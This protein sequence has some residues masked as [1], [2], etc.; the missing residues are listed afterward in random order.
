[1]N[2]ENLTFEVSIQRL[3]QIVRKMERGDVP[4]DEALKLFQEGTGL[5]QHCGKLLDKAELEVKTILPDPNGQPT[6]AEFDHGTD[7]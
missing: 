5:V 4:L 2:D 7:F 1:M 6:E 3:E